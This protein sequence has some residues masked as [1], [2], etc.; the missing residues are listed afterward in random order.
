MDVHPYLIHMPIVPIL[1][2]IIQGIWDHQVEY[3]LFGWY[4]N[5]NLMVNPLVIQ[6]FSHEIKTL[7]ESGFVAFQPHS[8]K[9]SPIWLGFASSD[10]RR[11]WGM[12]L[13]PDSLSPKKT[14]NIKESGRGCAS[15]S[16]ALSY[17]YLT[18]PLLISQSNRWNGSVVL[19]GCMV[20]RMCCSFNR[21][22]AQS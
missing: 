1:H 9:P 2:M 16:L 10:T 19:L 22:Y 12:W 15:Q 18:R 11:F 4:Q 17:H 21:A 3:N 8:S 20:V 6:P 5:L 14:Y 7:F 13:E